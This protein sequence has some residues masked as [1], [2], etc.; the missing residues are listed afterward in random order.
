MEYDQEMCRVHDKEGRT[1]LH[2]AVR[3]GQYEAVIELMKVNS[4]LFDEE[5]PVFHL[6][7]MYERLNLLI[8]LLEVND[9]D[10]SNIKD[11]N[12]DTILHTAVALKRIQLHSPFKLINEYSLVMSSDQSLPSAADASSDP[13]AAPSSEGHPTRDGNPAPAA[14]SGCC[15]EDFWECCCAILCCL[16]QLAENK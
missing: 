14:A 16:C 3:N 8:R 2:L 1:P 5:A 10:L 12:G 11:S 4:E 9:R 13:L 6:C 15:G 7:V